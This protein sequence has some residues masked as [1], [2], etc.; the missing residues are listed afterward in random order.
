MKIL[1]TLVS[2]AVLAAAAAPAQA[3]VKRDE[4]GILPEGWSIDEEVKQL[5]TSAKDFSVVIKSLGCLLYT[6]PSP[7]D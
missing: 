4:T 5:E 3:Q 6:S 1:W 7:R 2:V